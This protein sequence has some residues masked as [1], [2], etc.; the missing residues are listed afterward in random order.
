MLL[1]GGA[2]KQ[3]PFTALI[4]ALHEHRAEIR[5]VLLLEGSATDRLVQELSAPIAGRYKSLP[6][7]LERAVALA[8]PGDAV[9][10]SPACA[11]FGMFR[12]EFERGDQFRAWVAALAP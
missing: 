10:L 2:D 4:A 12:H 11:S 1:L 5:A 3:V 7:A 9:I 8:Q 6:A